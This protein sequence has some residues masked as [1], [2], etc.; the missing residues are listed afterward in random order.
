MEKTDSDP[1]S[2]HILPPISPVER[3]A[4]YAA[5]QEAIKSR[6]MREAHHLLLK[7]IQIDGGNP[8]LWLLL[9][10]TAPT[11]REAGVF[12]EH[13]LQVQPD[14]PLAICG[15][16]WSGIEW[17]AEESNHTAVDLP[18]LAQTT[19]SL[20]V[21]Y[22]N[23]HP[24]EQ[25]HP[26][27][28][29]G[30]KPLKRQTGEIPEPASVMDRKHHSGRTGELTSHISSTTNSYSNQQAE[31]LQPA[32][33]TV[34]NA[35]MEYPFL[36]DDER[37]WRGIGRRILAVLSRIGFQ[38]FL[39]LYLLGIT[40]AEL[41]T[42][43]RSHILGQAYHGT[44]LIVILLFIV[45]SRGL[46]YY[47]LLLALSLVPLFRL[48]SLTMPQLEI[49]QFY[50]YVLTGFFMLIAA[51]VV[52]RLAGFQPKQIGL[53]WP[54]SV[55]IQILIG[56]IGLGFGFI[57]YFILRPEPAV[58]TFSLP[59]ILLPAL[60]LIICPGFIEELI[61]RGILQRAS[62]VIYKRMAPTFIALLFA[63]LHIGYKS[64]VDI[65]FLFLVGLFFSFMVAKTHS[66]LGV[67]L[68]H[69]LAN[70]GLFLVFPF[71][72]ATPLKNYPVLPL[73]LVQIN[74]PAIW[75]AP[76]S[77]LP[78]P[79]EVIS[80][81]MMATS[82]ATLQASETAIV[83]DYPTATSTASPSDTEIPT[84]TAT[85]TVTPYR[86][87]TATLTKTLAP[88]LPRTNTPTPTQPRTSTSTLIPSPTQSPSP[89]ASDVP[90]PSLTPTIT[91]YPTDEW[92][93]PIPTDTPTLI[94]SE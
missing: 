62:S 19:G 84:G 46:K 91:P 14:Y 24:V 31:W 29:R 65:I 6:N 47:K 37:G 42:A 2:T 78:R 23:T 34:E 32:A 26:L 80:P 77:Y 44:I 40:S 10:W 4:V 49:G 35:G 93:T 22:R 9:A 45:F 1:D 18:G 63:I 73:P 50:A 69:G 27:V 52:I 48:I 83:A 94:I 76:F 86:S 54:K 20:D 59:A 61:F 33:W 87:P 85:W 39:V 58:P 75:S 70:I 82:T 36:D 64:W 56:I 25:A 51:V 88:L 41:V 12:F 79:E 71:V 16:A 53:I 92:P 30:S 74:A 89:T 38:A 15:V 90:V 68:A 72:L 13:L 17:T 81:D 3:D 21:Q 28:P 57:E 55:L 7:M 67:S 8:E 66:L 43:F 60:V 5:T 11:R